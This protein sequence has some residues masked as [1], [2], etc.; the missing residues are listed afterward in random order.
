MRTIQS[1]KFYLFNKKALAIDPC[2]NNAEFEIK[3]SKRI[4][5]LQVI[6]YFIYIY[7]FISCYQSS[8]FFF[9]P[10]NKKAAT[11]EDM[12]LWVHSLRKIREHFRNLAQ[13]VIEKQ[14]SLEF[15]PNEEGTT[16]TVKN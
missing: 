1:L 12:L 6:H 2:Y 10:F 15:I 8:L 14:V 7:L 4:Y 13:E 16:P 11:K 9:F 5:K 3:T